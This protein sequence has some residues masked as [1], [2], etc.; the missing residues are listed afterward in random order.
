VTRVVVVHVD[1]PLQTLVRGT[2]AGVFAGLALAAV[3]LVGLGVIEI[4]ERISRG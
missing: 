1:D 3:G 2:W 4:M